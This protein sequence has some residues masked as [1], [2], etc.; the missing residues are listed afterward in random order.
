MPG[1]QRN[2]CLFK[3]GEHMNCARKYCCGVSKGRR[4]PSVRFFLYLFVALILAEICSAPAMAQRLDGT[5]R[6]TVTDK[7]GAVILDAKVTVTNEGTS[8]GITATASSAGTHVLPDLL[9]GSYTV[10]AEK[11][12]SKKTVSGE[13]GVDSVV[14]VVIATTLEDGDVTAVV[15]VTA[16][17]ELVKTES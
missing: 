16:G 11:E 17:A 9:V 8:V 12:G 6:V 1:E 2:R 7:M 10:T 13:V 3:W 15:E 4:N 14:S 5:L